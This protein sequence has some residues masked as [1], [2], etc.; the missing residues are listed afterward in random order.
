[1]TTVETTCGRLDWEPHDSLAA[2]GETW[3]YARFHEP[4]RAKEAGLCRYWGSDA[5]EAL[6]AWGANP[7]NG[8]WWFIGDLAEARFREA[9]ERITPEVAEVARGRA[10]QKTLDYFSTLPRS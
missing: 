10:A 7:H 2:P 8:E 4:K 3:I 1:M 6:Q 5:C 9:L